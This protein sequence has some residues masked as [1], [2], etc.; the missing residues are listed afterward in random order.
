MKKIVQALLGLSCCILLW[1][2][3]YSSDVPVSKT[4]LPIDAK[5]LGTWQAENST[6]NDFI[7]SKDGSEYKIE[8]KE[9]KSGNTTVYKAFVSDVAG[10]KYMNIYEA[11]DKP[12]YNLYKLVQSGSKLTLSPVTENIT[13]KF[14]SSAELKAFIEKYQKL[15]FFF[16]KT[17]EVYVKK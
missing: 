1:G 3:P 9:T 4:G 15:S 5:L 13:E 12:S 6:D 17:D 8:K 2:C 7:V 11:A 10:V 14:S 16:D